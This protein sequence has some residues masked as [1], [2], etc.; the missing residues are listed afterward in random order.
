MSIAASFIEEHRATLGLDRFGP[1]EGWTSVQV[2]PRYRTSAHV[3]FLLVE[4]E[5][6]VP[7]LVLKVARFPHGDTALVREAEQVLRQADEKW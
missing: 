2:T 7:R 4:P 6:A 3:I 5:T 1:M